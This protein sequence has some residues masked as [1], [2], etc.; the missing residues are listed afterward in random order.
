MINRL[1][2][3]AKEE[4]RFLKKILSA[5][6]SAEKR[7]QLKNDKILDLQ[8]RIQHEKRHQ[9]EVQ[10]KIMQSKLQKEKAQAQRLKNAYE[11]MLE[12]E[13]ERQADRQER[14]KLA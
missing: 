1:N 7:S 6:E 13:R 10:T 14:A 12:F 3:L 4:Q 8:C 11:R 2:Y 9:E 5:R